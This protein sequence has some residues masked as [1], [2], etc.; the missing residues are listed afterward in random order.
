MTIYFFLLSIIYLKKVSSAQRKVAGWAGSLSKPYK[1]L[2]L[3]G[4]SFTWKCY[5][6]HSLFLLGLLQK[7]RR[8]GGADADYESWRDAA[9]R[10]NR[11]PLSPTTRSS[12]KIS[13]PSD[14]G[15][16]YWQEIKFLSLRKYKIVTPLVFWWLSL[17]INPIFY[18]W[19]SIKIRL[20][21]DSGGYHWQEIRFFIIEE[22]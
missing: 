3:A 16:Y 19:G 7:R 6:A 10:N 9:L 4:P 18:H 13:L 12:I 21:Y 15:G 14:F 8:D 1:G 11:Q 20:P 5:H 17:I 2:L 22:V